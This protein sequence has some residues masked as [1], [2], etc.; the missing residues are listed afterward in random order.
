MRKL[1]R[2]PLGK[3]K[4]IVGNDASQAFLDFAEITLYLR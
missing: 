3:V 2:L 1:A 4:A